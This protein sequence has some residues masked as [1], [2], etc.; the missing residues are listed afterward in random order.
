MEKNNLIIFIVVSAAIL[1]GWQFFY[2][3][4]QVAQQ[5]RRP[6]EPGPDGRRQGPAAAAADQTPELGVE[7]RASRPRPNRQR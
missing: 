5:E 2:V 6:A 4:P 7:G 3:A 1:F